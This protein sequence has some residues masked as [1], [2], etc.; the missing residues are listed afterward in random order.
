MFEN[1]VL[2]CMSEIVCESILTPRL[3]PQLLWS[4]GMRPH[5]YL[6]LYVAALFFEIKTE[7]ALIKL[8]PEWE[9]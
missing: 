4:L 8:V 7:N 3:L 1:Y 5:T 2:C 9:L 6:H